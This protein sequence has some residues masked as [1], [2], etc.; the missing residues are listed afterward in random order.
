MKNTQDPLPLCISS[1]Y[2]EEFLQYILENKFSLFKF[3]VEKMSQEERCF[4]QNAFSDSWNPDYSHEIHRAFYLLK[5]ALP[6]CVEYRQIYRDA[7]KFLTSFTKNISVLSIGCGAMLDLVGLNYAY[8]PHSKLLNISYHGI[9]ITDWKSTQEYTFP[10]I[11]TYFTCKDIN[12]T[13]PYDM[14][15]YYNIIIF[16]KSISDIPWESI[17]NFIINLPSNKLSSP[18]LL[19][20]SKRGASIDDINKAEAICNMIA[21]VHHYHFYNKKFL[22]GESYLGKNFTDLL[23]TGNFPSITDTQEHIS[24]YLMDIPHYICTFCVKHCAFTRPLMKKNCIH[25]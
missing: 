1:P 12:E 11:T 18:L 6:Y 16:P 21:E 19:I 9:D 8:S 2:L 17:K 25:I 4:I 10:N 7:L 3:A 23:D 5:Y 22:L 13:T 20:L 24:T 15:P 14:L